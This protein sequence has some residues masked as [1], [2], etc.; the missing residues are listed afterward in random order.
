MKRKL[1]HIF[2][3]YNEHAVSNTP[4]TIFTVMLWI[5]AQTL[6]QEVMLKYFPGYGNW[7]VGTL[8][9]FIATIGLWYFTRKQKVKK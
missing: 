4:A 5:G 7:V 6:I 9:V 2:K 3:D 8:E 1:R